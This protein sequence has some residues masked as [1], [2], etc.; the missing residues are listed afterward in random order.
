MS[1]QSDSND[2]RIVQ[3]RVGVPRKPATW[4]PCL[5]GEYC[6]YEGCGFV[7]VRPPQCCGDSAH[8]AERNK[9]NHV[10]RNVRSRKPDAT[11]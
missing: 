5:V 9:V 3:D 4:L 6:F 8:Q 1:S 2:D 7:E 11:D 10:S